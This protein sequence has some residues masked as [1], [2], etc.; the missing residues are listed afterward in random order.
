[1]YNK[2]KRGNPCPIFNLEVSILYQ[3]VHI[4]FTCT[5]CT[6]M[7][8]KCSRRSLQA[9]LLYTCTLNTCAKVV[10]ILVASFGEILLP[11]WRGN[12]LL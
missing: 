6:C 10:P 5:T 11:G 12:V 1:M 3:L 4:H 7:H 8:A 9:K 2:T